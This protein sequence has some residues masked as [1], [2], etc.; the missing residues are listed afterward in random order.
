MNLGLVLV[1]TKELNNLLYITFAVL[2]LLLS[3]FNLQNLNKQKVNVLGIKTNNSFWEDF[4]LKHPTYIDGWIELG[5]MDKVRQ[6]D[7]NYLLEP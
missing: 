3:L 2:I 6:I 5:R 7:P 1:M 4:M